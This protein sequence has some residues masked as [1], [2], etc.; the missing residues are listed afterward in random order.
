MIVNQFSWRAFR[1]ILLFHMSLFAC[2][3]GL[4]VEPNLPGKSAGI[5]VATFNVSMNRPADGDLRRDLSTPDDQVTAVANILRQVRPDVVL[6]NEFDYDSTSE[7]LELFRKDFLES[8]A[9]VAMPG[10]PLKYP[11]SYTA[12][13]NTGIN[14]GLDLNRNGSTNDAADAFGFGNFPG[15]YGMTVLSKLPIQKAAVRT[16][17]KVLWRDMPSAAVPVDAVTGKP[18]YPQEVWS[19]L[20]LSSKSH[21][22]V[23][24]TIGR[25]SLHLLASHPTPPA[26]DGAE[27]RNG[28]RNHDEIRF[29]ADYLSAERSEWIVDDSGT[30][31]GLTQNAHFVI[32]GDLNADPADGG[33]YNIAIRNLLRHKRVNAAVVPHSEGAR[34]AAIVQQKA[35]TRHSGDPAYDTADFSDRSVGNLRVDYVLPS[36]TLAVNSSGVYWPTAGSRRDQK[37]H[38]S[39]HHLV[40]LDVT[41][42]ATLATDVATDIE[43]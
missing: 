29:W 17:Q 15:Q 5:R 39:D 40:W 1:S 3:A 22:D 37:R 16:F 12:P 6:L 35:N 8:P 20:R 23:P 26:F 38:S 33:S 25:Q 4:C 13:V 34:Q 2:A 24:I 43:N 7:S 10:A 11:Y 9:S 14:S 32:L 31:G 30:S 36:L 19:Q 41:L 27:D 42:P 18:W 21:W 28:R